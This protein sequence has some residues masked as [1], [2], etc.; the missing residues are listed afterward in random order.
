M[1]TLLEHY[2]HFLEAALPRCAAAQT[3]ST[4]LASLDIDT[5]EIVASKMPAHQPSAR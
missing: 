2:R 4:A 1:A 5:V 3:A